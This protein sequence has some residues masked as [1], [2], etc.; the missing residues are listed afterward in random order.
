MSGM[1]RNDRKRIATKASWSGRAGALALVGTGL[2]TALA[3]AEVA[4]SPD[5]G[6]MSRAIVQQKVADGQP[7]TAAAVRDDKPI[8]PDQMLADAETYEREMKRVVEHAETLRAN[9]RRTHDIIRMTCVDDRYGQIKQVWIIAKPRFETIKGL[10]ADEFH[11][12]AQFTIIREG[13]DRMA[14]LAAEIETCTGDSLD[15]GIAGRL[16]EEGRGPNGTVTDPTLPPDPQLDVQR[17]QQAS[18]YQ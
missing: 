14:Q 15:P 8:S 11:M 17:P 3:A 18:P 9:A 1:M 7:P 2:V 5:N 4:S 6:A 13:A 10:R 12:R 16:E